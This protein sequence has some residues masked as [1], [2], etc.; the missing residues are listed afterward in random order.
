MY[1]LTKCSHLILKFNLSCKFFSFF[2][3]NM[4]ITYQAVPGRHLPLLSL[5]PEDGEAPGEMAYSLVKKLVY[6]EGRS[7]C[8]IT[9]M[10][11]GLKF[12]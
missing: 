11:H 1:F 9:K 7:W 10:A 8:S 3:L 6:R 5:P 4:G 12:Q 2:L